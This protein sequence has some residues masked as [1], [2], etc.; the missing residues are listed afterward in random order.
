MD[1]FR[2]KRVKL[3][4]K[5]IKDI[6]NKQNVTKINFLFL[7]SVIV[8]LLEIASL[9]SIPIFLSLISGADK[10]SKFA[11]I[12]KSFNLNGE[13]NVLIISSTIIF[14]LFLTKNIILVLYIYF[15]NKLF[16]DLKI[17]I[18]NIL[19]NRYLNKN[20]IDYIYSTPTTLIRNITTEIDN[21][22]NYIISKIILF[23]EFTLTFFIALLFI[24]FDDK[25]SILIIPSLII[26]STLFLLYFKKKIKNLSNK[27]LKIRASLVKIVSEG[28]DSFKDIKVFS[29]ERLVENYFNKE[30]NSLEDSRLIYNLIIKLPRVLVEIFILLGFTLFVIFKINIAKNF[31][32]FLPIIGFT[33]VS[34]VRLI[35]SFAIVNST[36]NSKRLFKV[37]F[38]TIHYEIMKSSEIKKE[39]LLFKGEI[40]K[41]E[42]KNINFDYK[43][44]NIL[45]NLN[46]KIKKGEFYLISGISGVGKTTLLNI[47]SGLLKPQEGDTL[48]NDKEYD[49]SNL[50]WNKKLGYVSQEVFM[51][52][53]SIE[54]N[55]IFNFDEKVVNKISLIDAAKLS[56]V[57]DFIDS[58]EKKYQTIVGNKGINLSGGQRQRIAIARALY[59]KPEILILD[60]ISSALD[61]KTEKELIENLLKIKKDCLIIMVTHKTDLKKYCDKSFKFNNGCLEDL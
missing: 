29:E 60:E 9:A 4:N 22:I 12:L 14:F 11:E 1:Y 37:C 16:R 6:V 52:D 46:F 43:K 28:F 36:V 23:K 40:N 42:L 26:I 58:Q 47:L 45:K 30:L 24:I 21:S 33:V 41:I 39:K 44:K 59:N 49:L 48:I 20:Y 19:L 18:G 32:E 54:K 51:L 2:S 25:S 8:N 56:R 53:A 55:I 3:I 31:I 50:N 10:F 34:L 7:L 13:G 27:F 35:P 38:E 5:K 17:N 61:D 15:E 57:D